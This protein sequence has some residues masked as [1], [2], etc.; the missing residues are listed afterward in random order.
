MTYRRSIRPRDK[1]GQ[2]KDQTLAYRLELVSSFS[3][4]SS[5]YGAAQN[6]A[7]SGAAPATT[8]E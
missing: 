5:S 7:F 8:L 6:S 2:R 1:N 3:A 4:S